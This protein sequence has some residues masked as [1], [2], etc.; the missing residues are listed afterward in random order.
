[1]DAEKKLKLIEL[2][3]ELKSAN[4]SFLFSYTVPIFNFLVIS[5]RLVFDFF[6]FLVVFFLVFFTILSNPYI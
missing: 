3:K 4:F 5:K 1:M 6:F 2:E